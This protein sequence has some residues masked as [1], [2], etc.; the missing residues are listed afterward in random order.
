[1]ETR[2][3]RW[4]LSLTLLGLW[5]LLG[6]GVG[7]CA[8][9]IEPPEPTTMVD[10]ITNLTFMFGPEAPCHDDVTGDPCANGDAFAVDYPQIEVKLKPFAIDRHEVSNVQYEYCVAVGGCSE[11]LAYNALAPTQ[12]EYYEVGSWDAFPM[13]QVTWQ[14]AQDY[15]S[16]VGR[17]LPYEF[18]WERVAKGPDPGNPRKYPAEDVEDF[19]DCKNPNF[20]GF[21]CRGD[22][23]LD[24]V[25]QAKA[26]F[27]LEKP[28]GIPINHMF[29]NAAEWVHE[30]YE[31]DIACAKELP[32]GCEDCAECS[33]SDTLCFQ[34]CQT[35]AQCAQSGGVFDCHLVCEGQSREYPLCVKHSA[36]D[37]PFELPHLDLQPSASSQGGRIVRG[38]AVQYGEKQSCR[39]TSSY[40]DVWNFVDASQPYIG[41]RC[42][43]T[44]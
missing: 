29:S 41:F 44:L 23:F 13:V 37:Q 35:C 34:T 10:I 14:Q 5:G 40:R 20:S 8:V 26:D 1:M 38:G 21:G 30:F 16:F 22:G 11:P 33:P 36:D 28:G 4:G 42:A 25:D 12:Q 15:C 19:S 18:E 17:R 3:S 6:Q 31:P 39:Y 9:G 43:K 32:E 2:S 24:A 27:V 7:S